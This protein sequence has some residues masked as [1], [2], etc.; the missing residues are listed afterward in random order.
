MAGEA[1]G[2]FPQGRLGGIANILPAIKG[3]VRVATTGSNITL[4][5]LQTVD[6]VAPQTEVRGASRL[7]LWQTRYTRRGVNRPLTDT[8]Q[9]CGM[10]LDHLITASIACGLLVGFGALAGPVAL[11]LTLL[12]A[13]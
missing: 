3:P 1:L 13:K 12:L 11:V 8:T 7:N 2:S 10:K 6:G 5:G 9:G 4:S